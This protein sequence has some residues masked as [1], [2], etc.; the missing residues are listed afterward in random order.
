MLLTDKTAQGRG[1]LKN[2]KDAYELLSE[3]A[4]AICG[5]RDNFLAEI[6]Q[7]YKELGREYT[8]PTELTTLDVE[9]D[10]ADEGPPK[11]Q[12]QYQERWSSLSAPVQSMIRGLV[13]VIV[14]YGIVI[15]MFY[16]FEEKWSGVENTRII[17][18]MYFASVTVS[19][20]GYGDVLPVKDSSRAVTMVLI[21]LGLFFVMHEINSAVLVLRG[22]IIAREKKMLKAIMRRMQAKAAQAKNMAECRSPMLKR[23]LFFKN[24]CIGFIET[25]RTKFTVLGYVGFLWV[26]I[27][28]TT[29]VF[30]VIEDYPFSE[31]LYGSICTISTVGYGDI[32]FKKPGSRL[33]A[34]WWLLVTPVNTIYALNGISN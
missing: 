6:A 15:F 24:S 9:D 4:V 14:Y 11:K 12:N 28:I 33:F 29:F 22:G 25:H 2:G 20:V 31:A 7:L 10:D 3:K 27:F 23:M 16:Q 18:A 26:N 19:T 13:V 21:M 8:A 17:D 34:V 5:E 30:Y 32:S 1:K